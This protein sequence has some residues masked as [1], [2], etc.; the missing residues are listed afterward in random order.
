MSGSHTFFRRTTESILCWAALFKIEFLK[1]PIFH[2]QVKANGEI[3]LPKVRYGATEN[4]DLE[5]NCHLS[6]HF[7]H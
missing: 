4:R 6:N 3:S 2:F 7:E 5:K 1:S